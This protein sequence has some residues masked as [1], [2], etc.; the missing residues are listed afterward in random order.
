MERHKVDENFNKVIDSITNSFNSEVYTYNVA[1]E[2][3]EGPFYIFNNAQYT[4]GAWSVGGICWYNDDYMGYTF[5]RNNKD[6][7]PWLHWC[8]TYNIQ[9]SVEE[10]LE[11]EYTEHQEYYYV[12][13]SMEGAVAKPYDKVKKINLFIGRVI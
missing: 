11:W 2:K 12:L 7:L 6:F 3:G 13:E 10:I 9:P 8:L 1:T 5:Y 4:S